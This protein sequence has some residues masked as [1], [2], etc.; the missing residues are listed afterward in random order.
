VEQVQIDTLAA[1]EI[2]TTAL[3]ALCALLIDAV[4]GGASVGWVKVPSAVEAS[5]YWSDVAE[6]VDA[7]G[8]VVLVARDAADVLGTVQLH[9]S[10]RPNGRHRAEVPGCWCTLVPDG[11]AS[12][13]RSWRP[14]RPKPCDIASVCWSSTRAPATH[15]N[16]STRRSATPSW[17]RFLAMHAARQETGAHLHPV[18]GDPGRCG[19][20]TTR[21]ILA[22]CRVHSL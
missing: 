5:N 3:Q 1:A 12:G 21:L 9:L 14:S 18:Q 13:L 15:L 11:V 4:A 16:A 20:N 7:A 17:G 2:R 6:H 8:V 19:G 22:G 10:D